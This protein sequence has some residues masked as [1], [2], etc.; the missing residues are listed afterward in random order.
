MT[1]AR[2]AYHEAGHAVA[3][4]VLGF[5]FRPSGIHVD[6]DGRG[7]TQIVCPT[8]TCSDDPFSPLQMSQARMVVVHFAGLFAQQ[9]FSPEPSKSAEDDDR[10]ID[11]YLSAIYRTDEAAKATARAYFE[12][13]AKRLVNTFEDVI[14]ELGDSLWSKEWIPRTENWGSALPQEKTM[15]ALAV[16]GILNRWNIFCSVDYGTEINE[17]DSA[18]VVT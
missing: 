14:R 1:D 13:E 3:A 9:K 15:D 18:G 4:A 7:V 6:Q 16:V 10:K 8:R 12:Q 2:Y 5:S 17:S 11:Q